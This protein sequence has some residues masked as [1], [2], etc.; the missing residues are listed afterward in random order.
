[1]H[2]SFLSI[3]NELLDGMVSET[4]SCFAA[5]EL[6]K[7]GL[8]LAQKISIR[9]IKS[10]INRV[11]GYLKDSSDI[12]LV[13]GGLGPT[14][15]DI[16]RDCISEFTGKR[17]SFSKEAMEDIKRKFH[18][19]NLEIPEENKKQAYILED[20]IIVNNPK[21]TAPGF[22]L[23]GTP[24]IAALP[25]VPSELKA[26]FPDI[27]QYLID[28]YYIKPDTTS[29]FAKTIG[30]PESQLDEK[31]KVFSAKGITVGTIAHYG[32]VDFRMDIPNGDYEEALEIARKEIAGVPEIERRIFSF[33]PEESIVSIILKKLIE[34]KKGD[35][36][37]IL[38]WWPSV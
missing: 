3:G 34:M 36:C 11:L 18:K 9:D 21:G 26:M 13:C 27:I 15:D 24:V 8:S 38:Y 23:P 30:I 22:I 6:S 33:D 37:R 19:M 32:Q 35:F 14:N 31:I 20:S 4:N 2:I 25:G 1:M 17:L 7:I 10:D 12:I 16:T 29:V 5:K 28:N